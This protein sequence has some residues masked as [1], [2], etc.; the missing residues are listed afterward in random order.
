MSVTCNSLTSLRNK[1]SR[2]TF[3]VPKP[4][5]SWMKFSLCLSAASQCNRQQEI[6]MCRSPKREKP[7]LIETRHQSVLPIPP[8][9]CVLAALR[10]DERR[11]MWPPTEGDPRVPTPHPVHSRPY[12]LLMISVNNGRYL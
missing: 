9:H 3:V 8:T 4:A 6:C 10:Q 11:K 7:L 5:R 2:R 12:S 1:I